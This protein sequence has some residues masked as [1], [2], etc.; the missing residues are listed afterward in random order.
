MAL[1]VLSYEELYGWT[2]DSIVKEVF[3]PNIL[4]K[5]KK[6]K[7]KILIKLNTNTQLVFNFRDLLKLSELF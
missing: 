5:L 7:L 4:L 6:K 1:K 3:D 2:M